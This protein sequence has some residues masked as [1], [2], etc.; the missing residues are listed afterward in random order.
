MKE[1][2]K[3]AEKNPGRIGKNIMRRTAFKK[4]REYEQNRQHIVEALWLGYG[5]LIFSPIFI[6]ASVWDIKTRILGSVM[7]IGFGAINLYIGYSLKKE[8]R[9]HEK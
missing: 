3:N 5:S 6:F 2:V 9:K 1:S 7:L 4:G 8:Q